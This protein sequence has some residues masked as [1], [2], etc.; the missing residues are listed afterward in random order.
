[1][2]DKLLIRKYQET[3]NHSVK[4][5]YDP[6]SVWFYITKFL[7]HVEVHECASIIGTRLIED[8]EVSSNFDAVNIAYDQTKTK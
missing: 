6:E 2:G 1:M 7:K 4:Q 5:M 3:D 8:N